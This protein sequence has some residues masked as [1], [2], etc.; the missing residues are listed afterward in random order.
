MSK[1]DAIAEITKIRADIVAGRSKFQDIARAR[2]D[3]SSA[4]RGGDL[5]T[6]GPGQMQRPFEE[7]TYALAV[8]EMSG[9]VDTDSG[10]HLILR[11]A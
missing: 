1:E 3:C 11:T 4:Q 10:V 5:G 8:G 7:A 9:V 2:S 6:F